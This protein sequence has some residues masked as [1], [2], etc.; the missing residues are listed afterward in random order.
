MIDRLREL[1]NRPV[2][3]VWRDRIIAIAVGALIFF[4]VGYALAHILESDSPRPKPKPTPTAP[5]E[6]PKTKP[7]ALPG[8]NQVADEFSRDYLAYERSKIKPS[9][10]RHAAVELAVTLPKPRCTPASCPPP[11]VRNKYGH[12]KLLITTEGNSASVS[13]WFVLVEGKG[14]K[15]KK[16]E[17]RGS[18]LLTLR[19][20]INRGWEVVRLG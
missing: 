4:V 13:Y 12:I 5:V 16:T 9:Q 15:R 20:D 8:I 6:K 7:K 18:L 2:S 14:R 3:P 11:L 1:L 17:E 19:R 10:I